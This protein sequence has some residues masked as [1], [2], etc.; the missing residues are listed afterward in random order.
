[1]RLGKHYVAVFIVLAIFSGCAARC[2]AQAE[3]SKGAVLGAVACIADA[4]QSYAL[5]LPQSYST[6]RRWPIIYIFDPN[7]N[8][9]NP[10]QLYKDVAER[11]G[12]VLAASNNSRNGPIDVSVKAAMSVWADTHGR[13]SLDP[14]RLYTMGFSGG[15]RIAT[16]IALRAK[17]W[18]IAGVIAH[19]ATYPTGTV[20]SAEDSFLYFTAVGEED[21]NYPEFASIRQ[22]RD[23]LSLPTRS[24][25][26]QGTHQWAPVSV[27]EQALGWLTLKEMQKGVRP[28]D[29]AFVTEQ[30]DGAKRELAS[31]RDTKNGIALH[32]TLQH[33]VFDFKGLRPIDEFIP[34]LDS[35]NHSDAMKT[36]IRQEQRDIQQQDSLT[37]EGRSE[38]VE[39]VRA[40]ADNALR[41]KQSFV[42][43]MQDLHECSKSDKRDHVI[44]SRAFNDLWAQ[45]IEEG[46]AYS[47][48][49]KYSESV[50]L[51]RLMALVAPDRPWPRLLEADSLLASGDNK[52]AVAA[53]S[54]A[55][56]RGFHNRQYFAQPRFERLTAIK[57]FRDLLESISER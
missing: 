5:Y 47:E 26:F 4:K 27:M 49:G 46:Q 13:L 56:K 10:V 28:V 35:S 11:Y 2:C 55:V 23:K 18:Q 30:F 21:F 22:A 43:R 31:L 51:F 1:M 9:T 29:D 25:V 48:R 16:L 34:A 33:L 20:P 36:S 17:E 53:L 54:D 12:F 14:Q 15:A 3:L 32:A 50:M 37:K 42:N 38:L 52:G 8:G 40:D 24:V 44:C 41:M 57:S 7:A 39:L 45:G 19:G 6:A